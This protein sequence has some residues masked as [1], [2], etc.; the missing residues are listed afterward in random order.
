MVLIAFAG[1]AMTSAS[2]DAGTSV[3]VSSATMMRG[4]AAR[5]RRMMPCWNGCGR[6]RFGRL[7]AGRTL[8]V[9]FDVGGC[10]AMTPDDENVVPRMNESR[11]RLRFGR[12]MN[13]NSRDEGTVFLLDIYLT[14]LSNTSGCENYLTQC[15][16]SHTLE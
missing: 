10:F 12:R 15:D 8:A 1:V 16:V 13:E 3:A 2:G 14:S 4:L 7:R 9:A 5:R 6:G 11:G